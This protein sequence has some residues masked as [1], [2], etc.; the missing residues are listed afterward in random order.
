MGSLSFGSEFIGTGS[1]Y[2]DPLG[3]LQTP[4]RVSGPQLTLHKE[5][6]T[7]KVVWVGLAELAK[8]NVQRYKASEK[9]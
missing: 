8:A 4:A 7:L 6:P 3:P 2:P 5:S 9:Q 1:E